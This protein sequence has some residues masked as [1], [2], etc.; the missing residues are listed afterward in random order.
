MI[1]KEIIG[2]ELYVYMKGELL[3][4]RWLDKDYGMVFDKLFGNFTSKNRL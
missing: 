4:K 2:N 1:Y 3:Y